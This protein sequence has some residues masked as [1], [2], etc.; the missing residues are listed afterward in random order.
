MPGLRDVRPARFDGLELTLTEMTRTELNAFLKRPLVAVL[1][2]VRPAGTLHSTPV[3]FEFEDETF[4]FWVSGESVKAISARANPTASVCIATHDEPYQYVSAE[5]HCEVSTV[6]VEDRCLS[7]CSRYYPADEARAFVSEE[8]LA[9]DSV[10]L[11]LHP[12]TIM[13]ERS[14]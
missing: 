3:W 5:G 12:R 4:Y 11:I 8:L 9:E 2:T 1:T 14:A 6:G 7:I 13:S 10:I